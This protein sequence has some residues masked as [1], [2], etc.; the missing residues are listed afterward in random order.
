[1]SKGKRKQKQVN[2]T[3]IIND[4]QSSVKEQ[5]KV[6]D[7]VN[8][9]ALEHGIF[10]HELVNKWIENADNKVNI[11]CAIFTALFGIISF[12]TEQGINVP[13]NP[14]INEIWRDSHRISFIFSLIFM[15]IGIFFFIRAIFPNLKSSGKNEKKYPIYFGDIQALDFNEYKA[16]VEK[17]NNEDFYQEILLESHFNS[18][19]CMKK[20]RRYS[21]IP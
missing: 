12:L 5:P 21:I 2:K 4:L 9:N 7:T 16:K 6:K 18:G 20:M 13:N 10:V 19:V 14:V 11:S 3:K 15:V 17:A 1:M 8:E